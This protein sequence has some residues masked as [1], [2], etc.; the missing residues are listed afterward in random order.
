ML[1]RFSFRPQ[2]P[3]RRPQAPPHRPLPHGRTPCPCDSRDADLE[4]VVLD[5]LLAQHDDAE[6]DAELH[7]A[8]P[9]G[10]LWAESGRSD[11]GMLPGVTAPGNRGPREGSPPPPWSRG[12]V[13]ALDPQK[14]LSFGKGVLAAVTRLSEA[15]LEWG[16]SE[17]MV[18]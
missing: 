14:G 11:P 18:S 10:A 8:A 4:Q 9:R 15:P 7:Q 16:G 6:L 3:P 12:H 2:A 1:V 17:P 5:E 13:P